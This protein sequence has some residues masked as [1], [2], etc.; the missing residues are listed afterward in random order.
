MDQRIHAAEMAPECPLLAISGHSEG[1]SRTSALPPKADIRIAVPY[2]P[3]TNFR[4]AP[5]SGHKWVA[6]VM[7]AFDPKRTLRALRFFG[8]LTTT[9]FTRRRC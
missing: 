5:N 1:R 7:S 4:F 9:F 3:L 6:E 8:I 2:Q